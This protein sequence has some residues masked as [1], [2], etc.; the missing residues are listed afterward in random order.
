[1]I[2]L[3]IGLS[4]LVA[5]VSAAHYHS[6]PEIHFSWNPLQRSIRPGSLLAQLAFAVL[7]V[8][9][10]TSEYSS[11]MIRTSLTAVPKRIRMMSAK[12]LVFGA[13]A[14]LVGEVISVAAFSIGQA[15][16]HGKAPSASFG[17]HL[18]LRVVLGAGLY[19]VLI[20]LYG[21]AVAL[22]VRHAAA[23]IAIVVGTLFIV[24][25]VV[26]LLPSSWVNPIEEYWPAGVVDT[27]AGPQIFLTHHNSHAL[28]AWQG[29][30]EFA[31]FVGV[32][33]AVAFYFL[34]RRD[35]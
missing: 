2:V 19:L 16:I 7:G 32:V 13:S 5:G 18:V 29:L 1:A 33:I 34:E 3:G 8:I 11:G 15:L 9:T 20:G 14:L 17:Q 25:G 35:A 12:L 6:D 4:A 26:Q 31:L 21:S 23:G 24:P 22:L 27:N 10:V 30:G 28:S